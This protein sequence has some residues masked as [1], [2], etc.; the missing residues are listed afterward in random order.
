M[1]I[2]HDGGV[3]NREQSSG[4][5]RIPCLDGIRAISISLV[6]IAHLVG[7]TGF[8]VPA[9]WE[10]YLDLGQLGVRVF[11]VISGYLITTL[12]LVEHRKYGSISLPQFYFR[13]TF[14]IF[15]AFYVFIFVILIAETVGWV[16]LREHDLLHAITYTSNYHRD[17]A[18]EFGHLW[19]L[20]VEEQF[21]LLWPLLFLLFGVRGAIATAAAYMVI[22][23]VVRVVTWQLFPEHLPGVGET[24][25]TVADAIATGCVLAATRSWLGQKPAFAA[26]QRSALTAVL[27]VTMIFALD[28]KKGSISVSYPVGETALNVCIALFI[29]WCLRNPTGRLGAFLEWRP[30]VY[31]GLLSYSLY[32]WQ[33]PFANRHSDA[34]VA[35]F[36]LNLVCIAAAA[37]ASYYLIE[38]PS[39]D[40]RQRLGRR[41]PR[42]TPGPR[43]DA[44]PEVADE[45]AESPAQASSGTA[46]SAASMSSGEL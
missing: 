28:H 32:L 33:Q 2:S 39:L 29:D 22:A 45:V 44:G 16:A 17:R 41:L 37:L 18:W 34:L 11:F 3:V 38:K 12:L 46:R 27:L 36:P 9:T 43:P 10:H 1:S 5:P 42:R 8:N 26:M 7:T 14:R 15:P 40:W 35:S 6:L 31:I 30:V 24:F 19:S 13:R 4:P 25:Q 23:P 20:A 21:Y